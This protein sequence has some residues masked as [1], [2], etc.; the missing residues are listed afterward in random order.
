MDQINVISV[1]KYK[2]KDGFEDDFVEALNSYDYS[3]A[4]LPKLYRFKTTSM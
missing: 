4:D 1:M 2:I 3:K